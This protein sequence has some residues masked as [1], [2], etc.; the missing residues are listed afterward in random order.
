MGGQAELSSLP[1]SEQNKCKIMNLARAALSW[2]V[3]RCEP[4]LQQTA[5]YIS[6]FKNTR[7]KHHYWELYKCNPN[8]RIV[9]YGYQ[10]RISSEKGLNTM[11]RRYLKGRHTL[12]K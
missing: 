5:G 7:P 2:L 4:R 6:T 1:I 8:K 10:K 11:W 12:W 3:P 9:K